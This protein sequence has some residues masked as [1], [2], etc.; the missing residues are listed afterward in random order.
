MLDVKVLVQIVFGGLSPLVIEDIKSEGRVVRVWGRT[1]PTLTPCPVCGTLSARVHAYA[2]QHPG[3]RAGGLSWCV[4]VVVRLRRLVCPVLGCA[5]QTFR[6]Q[7][8]GAVE[9]YQRRTSRL[10]SQFGA[11]VRELA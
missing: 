9:R 4:A 5:R 10:A 8:P 2:E 7:V 11:V 1:P 3:R 6:D